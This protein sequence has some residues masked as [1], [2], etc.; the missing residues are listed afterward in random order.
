MTREEARKSI[1]EWL[2]AKRPDEKL[3]IE[4]SLNLMVSGVLDSLSMM[5]LLIHVEKLRGEPISD[6]QLDL[7]N[8]SSIDI[9]VE[10]FF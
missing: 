5:G 3:A 6:D 2:Q 4:D 9:I 8:F 10:T 1:I 7:A